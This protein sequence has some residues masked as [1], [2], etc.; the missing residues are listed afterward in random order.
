MREPAHEQPIAP[1]KEPAQASVDSSPAAPSDATD[2]LPSTSREAARDDPLQ[3]ASSPSEPITTAPAA[4]ASSTAMAAAAPEDEEAR[5]AAI[6]SAITN[7]ELYKL[8][9]IFSSSSV[10]VQN[11]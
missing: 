10:S 9:R 1:L 3:S 6:H 7:D 8:Q 5:R 2:P 4:A 11:P